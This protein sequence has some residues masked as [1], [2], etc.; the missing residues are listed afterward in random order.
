M[1]KKCFYIWERISPTDHSRLL[2]EVKIVFNALQLLLINM[3]TI[4]IIAALHV[5]FP[6]YIRSYISGHKYIHNV[7]G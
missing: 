1:T 3:P 6:R 2:I 4:F 5:I 7:A